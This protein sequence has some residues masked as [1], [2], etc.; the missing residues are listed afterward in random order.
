MIPAPGALKDKSHVGMSRLQDVTRCAVGPC[1]LWLLLP[2]GICIPSW[3]GRHLGC[4]AELAAS[5]GAAGGQPVW[6]PLAGK[7]CLWWCFQR[8]DELLRAHPGGTSS[9]RLPSLSLGAV[10][11]HSK[12][13]E[14][15]GGETWA[16]ADEAATKCCCSHLGTDRRIF[17][18]GS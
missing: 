14:L 5:C 15:E 1:L 18:A 2:K 4:R 10:V 3:A 12:R 16:A 11:Q 7:Q 17:M 9:Q 6:V 13:N 8:R